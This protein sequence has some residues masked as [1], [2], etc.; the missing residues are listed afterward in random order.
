MQR[1]LHIVFKPG[2]NRDGYFDAKEILAQVD[3]A[4]DIFER[5]TN[6]LAQGL[7]MF[8]NAPSHMK[9]ATDAISATKMVKS[10]SYYTS[11]Y[12]FVFLSMSPKDP[13]R[14]WAHHPNGP[15]MRDGINPLT[16]GPQSF[17]FPRQPY[18]PIIRG[19]SRSMEQIIR[20]TRPLAR[21]QA[22]CRVHWPQAS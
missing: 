5:R 10:A 14:L 21:A 11:L 13:K 7:F 1:G 8:D 4:I 20:E 6:G 3:R 19:G 16:G 12:V 2:K 17:Y 15:C 9:R 18:P 22:P